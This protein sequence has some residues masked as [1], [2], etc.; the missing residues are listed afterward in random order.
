MKNYICLLLCV[1][2]LGGFAACSAQGGE[3]EIVLVTDAAGIED[4]ARNE[5]VWE[6]IRLYAGVHGKN[7]N[8]ILP[9]GS[10]EEAYLQAIE[11]A[12]RSGAALVVLSGEGFS[13]AAEELGEQYPNTS[14]V[15]VDAG[16]VENNPNNLFSL[17]LSEE[18]AGYMAGYMAVLNGQR[19][20]GFLGAE[21][22]ESARGYGFGFAQGAAAAAEELG[23][24]VEMRYA[25][26]PNAQNED[27]A[28]QLA[29]EWFAAGTELIFVTGEPMS[30]G[31]FDV[32]EEMGGL[33]IGADIDRENMSPTV[34][35]SAVK[36][37]QS[38]I[39]YALGLYDASD[40]LVRESETVGVAENA[41]G[42]AMENTR[43]EKATLQDYETLQQAFLNEAIAVV[44]ADH[45]SLPQDTLN[46]PDSIR[47]V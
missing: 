25:Y 22:S 26:V 33:C 11:D 19:A 4:G 23:E 46:L 35:T 47:F 36:Y 29:S 28:V 14:F 3:S 42:L 31:V 40:L 1:L 7:V 27:S 41:V 13:F 38:A 5:D 32:A 10:D 37:W 30:I 18:E 16:E 21:Q 24:E 12:V 9:T 20:L 44:Q 45:H 43:F 17:Q 2:C 6:G 39:G 15:L 34:Q 8:Y